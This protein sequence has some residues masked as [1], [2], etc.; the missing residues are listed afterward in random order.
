MHF[1]LFNNNNHED[2]VDDD[3]DDDAGQFIKRLLWLNVLNDTNIIEHKCTFPSVIYI[4]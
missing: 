1:D 4:L 3:D 2:G